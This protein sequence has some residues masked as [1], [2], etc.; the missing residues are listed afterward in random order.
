METGPA[1]GGA[2][3][4]QRALRLGPSS[5]KRP[6]R[7]RR[8]YPPGGVAR[9]PRRP[10]LRSRRRPPPPPNRA[11]CS[12]FASLHPQRL[13]RNSAAGASGSAGSQPTV[14]TDGDE[15]V[16]MDEIQ[17]QVRH[18]PPRRHSVTPNLHRSLLPVCGR[19][20][21]TRRSPAAAPPRTHLQ[22]EPQWLREASATDK[23]SLLSMVRRAA[24]PTTQTAPLRTNGQSLPTRPP[25]IHPLIP[26]P[27]T[28]RRSRRRSRSRGRS[29]RRRGQTFR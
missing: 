21:R 26:P 17:L 13:S 18:P 14:Y 7:P 23:R 19:L 8:R 29:R 6:S 3:R 11:F 16:G 5:F 15:P 24:D 25:P 9:R 10:K 1:A 4:P 22:E 28:S 2:R 12:P 27:V 20:C